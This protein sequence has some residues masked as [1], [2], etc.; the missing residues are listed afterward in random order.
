MLK[1]R[2]K[3]HHIYN[4]LEGFKGILPLPLILKGSYRKLFNFWLARNEVMKCTN[5]VRAYWGNNLIL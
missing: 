3:P 4:V 2:H 1:R 5:G